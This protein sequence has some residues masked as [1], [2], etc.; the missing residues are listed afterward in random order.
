VDD[1][2]RRGG[3]SKKE[4]AEALL[5]AGWGRGCTAVSTEP[6]SNYAA[7]NEARAFWNASRKHLETTE[8]GTGGTGWPGRQ[9][10]R[11][12][13][14]ELPLVLENALVTAWTPWT[15]QQ[16]SSR[17]DVV[18]L[19]PFGPYRP[20]DGPKQR[21]ARLWEFCRYVQGA[22][23]PHHDFLTG[24][25]PCWQLTWRPPQ[26]LPRLAEVNDLLRS[27][28]LPEEWAELWVA[29]LGALRRFDHLAEETE[30][31]V[32]PLDGLVDVAVT[33]RSPQVASPCDA[34]ADLQSARLSPGDTLHLPRNAYFALKAGPGLRG[35]TAERFVSGCGGRLAMALPSPQIPE[36]MAAFDE[37]EN[38]VRGTLVFKPPVE[39][40]PKTRRTEEMQRKKLELLKKR[41]EDAEKLLKEKEQKEKEKRQQEMQVKK[42]KQRLELQKKEQE[43]K[44][45]E[46][47][48]QRKKKDGGLDR[49]LHSLLDNISA[50]DITAC[51]IDLNP[52]R[53]RLLCKNLSENTWHGCKMG[54]EK[55]GWEILV[56]FEWCVLLILFI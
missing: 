3:P 11:S 19:S 24:D 8:G 7:L 2:R 53:L 21:R 1:H 29:P 32:A 25:G 42:E 41:K 46:E 37:E 47:E 9:I 15:F 34:D 6:P 38:E 56:G 49:L 55:A 43:R 31:L 54:I 27:E 30:L 51:G 39:I 22:M 16:L 35:A 33:D 14:D 26:A 4:R 12:A 45:R 13:S 23:P 20:F 10:S 48:E 50:P 17:D 44:R 18:L 28:A 36:E 5:S 52:A 40:L